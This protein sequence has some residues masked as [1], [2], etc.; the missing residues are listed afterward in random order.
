MR[1][2]PRIPSSVRASARTRTS[3]PTGRLD[4]E[5]RVV[6]A[7]S[8]ARAVDEHDVVRTELGLPAAVLELARER[9]QPRAALLLLLRRDRIVGSGLRAR[10]RRVREDVDPRQPGRLDRLE[11]PA[12]GSLVLGREADDHVARQ[13]ELAG[14]RLETAQEG[15]GR[16][17]AAH[18]AQHAV[19][20]RLQRHVQVPG[21]GGRLAER[22]DEGVVDVVDLD[23]AEP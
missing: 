7:V 8:T 6:V 17:A 4:E 16:V 13:V 20:A 9:S 11:R 21:D 12:E 22:S 23:R 18:R 14:Q 1:R 2:R 15:R 5:R 3:S 19:V 10:A